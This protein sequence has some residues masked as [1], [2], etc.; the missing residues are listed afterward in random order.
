VQLGEVAEIVMGQ[1]PPS[2]ECNKDSRG[3]VFVKAGEFDERRPVVREWTTKPLRKARVGDVLV[4]VVGATAGRVNESIECAIGR[5][6]AA[7]RPDP[8][9][10][11]S[12]YL[13][14]FLSTQVLALRAKSQGLAQGVIT[15][16]MLQE[17]PIPLPQLPEQQGIADVLDRAE[18]LR[19]I[20]R[21]ALAQLDSLTQAIFLDS[22]GDSNS[23]LDK[24]DKRQLGELL[25]FLTSGSRGWAK[26]YAKSGDL[27]LRIQNV[28]HDRLVLE[29]IA[30]VKA[31]DNAEA[32]RARVQA[33]DVL[34]S[35]TADLGRSG[36][37]PEGLGPAFINQHLAILRTT[38]LVPRF[39]SAYLASP[40]GQRQVLGRNR[41]GVKAGL[42]FDDIRSLTVPVPPTEMQCTFARRVDAVE[43]LEEK[44]QASL[45]EFDALFASLRHR[46]FR[47]EL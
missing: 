21:T 9:R 15:R 20:R 18:Q 17:V 3:T 40:A 10:L 32:R 14:H 7:V 39:L 2:A 12:P 11:V 31:P 30:Y 46:A 23:V 34:L 37:F 43:K 38:V 5:S 28:Q 22:F 1:A 42:N 27:F 33:G 35:I 26:Y 47:G 44:H 45:A 6:V 16:E 4:C 29:D 24:W 13:Y 36:V 25:D 41:Q 19:V 8:G